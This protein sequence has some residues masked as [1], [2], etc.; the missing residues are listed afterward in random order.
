MDSVGLWL[1]CPG[2]NMY[3][4]GH[5]GGPLPYGGLSSSPSIRW[6]GLLRTLCR[7]LRRGLFRRGERGVVEIL[8]RPAKLFRKIKRPV[9]VHI[10]VAW[11]HGQ[12]YFGRA[13]AALLYYSALSHIRCLGQVYLASASWVEVLIPTPCQSEPLVN[14]ALIPQGP[15]F[16]DQHYWLE[17][18]CK[19][20]HA[21]KLDWVVHFLVIENHSLCLHN[22]R[23]FCSCHHC[24]TWRQVS[25]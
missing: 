24:G 8:K 23:N 17:G 5:R 18:A 11:W 1:S 19:L 3:C 7:V 22:P 25:W 13:G 2:R 15:L 9:L 6:G 12:L 14:L 10:W 4:P 20:L 21:S 16:K